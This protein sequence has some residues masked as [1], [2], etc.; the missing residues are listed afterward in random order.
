MITGQSEVKLTLVQDTDTQKVELQ[1]SLRC[2]TVHPN[3]VWNHLKLDADATNLEY[4]VSQRAEGLAEY[5]NLKYNDLHNPPAVAKAARELLVDL[6]KQAERARTRKAP[7]G[8]HQAVARG[9]K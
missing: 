1:V 8:D 5:Q 3:T 4:L 9:L 7:T 2:N 6:K